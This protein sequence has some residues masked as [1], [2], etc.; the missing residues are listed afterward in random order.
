MVEIDGQP[1]QQACLKRVYEGMTICTQDITE[2]T[3]APLHDL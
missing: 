2:Q 3:E 1:N